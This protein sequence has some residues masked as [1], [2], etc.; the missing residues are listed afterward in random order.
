MTI[1]N[2]KVVSVTYTLFSPSK[3]TGEETQVE[4]ADKS[5]PLVWLYGTG[6]MIPDFEKNL[7]GKKTGHTFDFR[8]ASENAYGNYDETYVVK[9][10]LDAF[11]G[12]DG[13]IDTESVKVGK[14]L[15][16]TDTQG[17]HLQGTVKEISLTDVKMDF[18]HP[19]AG[20]DLHFIGEIIEVRNATPEELDHGHVHGTHGH[21]H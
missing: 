17:N 12:K 2:K 19:M 6:S 15:P 18:N 8:I 4:K 14:T 5:H 11:R 13:S 9:V 20:K 16:M 1:E 21:H 10:P 3:I 7:K